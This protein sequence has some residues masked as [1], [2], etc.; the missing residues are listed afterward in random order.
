MKDG[1]LGQR[2]FALLWN[3]KT[4]SVRSVR[5]GSPARSE[6]LDV[7]RSGRHEQL[8]LFRLTDPG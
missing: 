6:F 1:A 8:L 2:F 3:A 4:E 5:S 7:A